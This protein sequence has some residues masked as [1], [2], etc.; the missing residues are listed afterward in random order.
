MMLGLRGIPNVQGGVEKHVEMLSSRLT[1]HGWEVE[2]VG[3]RRYLP[4]SGPHLWNGVRVSPLSAPRMM[5]L[6]A[7]IHTF[8][9]ICFA[10][11]RRPDVLHI[12]AV[13][14][15][16]LVPLARLMRLNV[17]VTHHGY[18]YDRQKWGA[19]AKKML[20]TGERMGMRLAHGR[21]AIS[22][23]IAETMGERYRV[24]VAFVPNGVAV[25]HCDVETG[26][27]GE[28]GLTRRR[29]I[30]LAARLVPEKRQIDLIKAYAKLGNTGFNLVLAGGAEFESAY[31][32]EV[33]ALASRVPGVVLTGF[34]T[35]DRLAELFANAALFVL[36]S[37]HEGMPIALLEAMAHGLPV[38]ASDIVAN[39]QLD[40]PAGDYFPLGDIDALASAISEKTA[41]SLDEQEVLAQ[42][43]RVES[44]YSWSSVAL[45]TLDVYRAVTK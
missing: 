28:F 19:F 43:E 39:R 2:V 7:I 8:L 23:E 40:L 45:K 24:P 42:T 33:R 26:V 16:L 6:E 27:L 37:S 5:A 1:G 18:D 36:P 25:S 32:D 12:H 31:E 41:T 35:G 17:V 15:A 11:M 14:P 34:Q 20:R 21:I 10:A 9:G 38:L 4:V 29:Y 13:G 44:A 22:R 3:R 30:L